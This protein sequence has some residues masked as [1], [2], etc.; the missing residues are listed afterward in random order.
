MSEQA[1]GTQA[2]ETTEAAPIVRRARSAGRLHQMP[3]ATSGPIISRNVLM[4]SSTKEPQT[5][6]E[7][8]I[9]GNLPSWEPLP[10]GE[11]QVQRPK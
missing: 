3:P 11:L 8:N 1:E 10:P 7:R 6:R 9:A 5:S 4:S 2:T